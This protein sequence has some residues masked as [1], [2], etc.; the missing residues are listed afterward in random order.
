LKTLKKILI[1][2]KKKKLNYLK[3]KNKQVII[4]KGGR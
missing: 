3:Y 4:S 2:N 1:E